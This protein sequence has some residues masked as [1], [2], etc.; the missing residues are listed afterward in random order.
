MT[1]HAAV[2]RARATS[3]STG[4]STRLPRTTRAGR[5]TALTT[6]G[7]SNNLEFHDVSGRTFDVDGS[8]ETSASTAA[9]GVATPCHRMASVTPSS[10]GTGTR[11]ADGA[12]ATGSC[13][14]S[15]FDGVTLP[16]RACSPP[17]H[18]G[19][20]RTPTVSSRYGVYEQRDD[21]QLDVRAV[22]QH[23][24]RVLHRLWVN[25]RARGREQHVL[26]DHQRHVLRDP[27]RAT[28]RGFTCATW[29]SATTA[30]TRTSRTPAIRR[31]RRS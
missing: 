7:C 24:H 26:Q 21:P 3:R 29:C 6:D 9:R 28:S 22:R 2:Y 19:A 18:S 14:T 10:R 17:R 16:R 27:D 23:V 30:T 5:S 15:S 4:R 13:P 11:A 20:A 8:S 31:R 25:S 1:R 12:V